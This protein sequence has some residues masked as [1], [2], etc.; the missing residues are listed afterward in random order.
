MVTH[1]Y[2][3]FFF[4]IPLVFILPLRSVNYFESYDY[5]A[6]ALEITLIVIGIV[7]LVSI[8]FLLLFLNIRSRYRKR[9]L[10]EKLKKEGRKEEIEELE[11]EEFENSLKFDLSNI[12][13]YDLIN[14]G[15][16]GNGFGYIITLTVLLFMTFNKPTY[17]TL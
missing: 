2:L 14:F 11:K 17:I 7:L 5:V 8:V 4:F 1:S 3:C 6:E 16:W 12:F 9:K 13:R 10:K 15:L